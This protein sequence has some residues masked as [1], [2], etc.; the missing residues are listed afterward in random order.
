MKR[1][2][3]RLIAALIASLITLVVVYGKPGADTQVPGE[4]VVSEALHPVVAVVD[5][6]TIRVERH[7]VVEPVRFIGIDTPEIP[8]P[9]KVGECFGTEAKTRAHELLSGTQV[10]L[11]YD[12]SQ[13]ERDTYGRLLA[14]PFL[15]DGTNVG[16]LLVR[17]GFAR[18]Y[19][20]A[21]P[22][23]YQE[24]YRAA[25]RDAKRETRGMWGA[26]KR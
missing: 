17:E 9:D 22:Y 15:E 11:E 7:G 24:V 21:A 14:Y 8:L 1:N 4:I 16:E 23:A 3:R 25:A 12:P 26:C 19:T 6:D 2:T 5:G 18:E 20:F 10:R 13:G